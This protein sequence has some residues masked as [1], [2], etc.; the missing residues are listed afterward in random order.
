MARLTNKEKEKEELKKIKYKFLDWTHRWDEYLKI[1]GLTNR[2]KT[3]KRREII[4]ELYLIKDNDGK[5]IISG[6]G[7]VLLFLVIDSGKSWKSYL[8]ELLNKKNY[9]CYFE[10]KKY[11]HREKLYKIDLLKKLKKMED[12]RLILENYGGI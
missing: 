6:G 8:K 11:L 7:R 1:K 4:D 12:P 9:D 5:L 2:N 3:Q 10:V